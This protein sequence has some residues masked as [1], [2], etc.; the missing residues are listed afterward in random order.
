MT[1]SDK[2]QELD[3]EGI[4]NNTSKQSFLDVWCGM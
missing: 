1:D 4:S 2:N 3:Q